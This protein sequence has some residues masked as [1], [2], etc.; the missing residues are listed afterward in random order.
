MNPYGPIHECVGF[1]VWVG[2]GPV[3]A[4]VLEMKLVVDAEGTWPNEGLLFERLLRAFGSSLALL[5]SVMAHLSALHAGAMWLL[6][7][8]LFWARE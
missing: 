2:E 5:T 3:L 4:P 6:E 8:I 7:E 1:R